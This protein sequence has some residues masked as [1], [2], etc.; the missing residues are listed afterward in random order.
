MKEKQKKHKIK[1][2]AHKK[3]IKI[4]IEKITVFRVIIS[5]LMG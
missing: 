1:K 4:F 2:N 5:I 3:L